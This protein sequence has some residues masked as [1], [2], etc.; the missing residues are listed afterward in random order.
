M[1]VGI[2]W[3]SGNRADI[4]G[5]GGRESAVAVRPGLRRLVR[6]RAPRSFLPD[7]RGDQLGHEIEEGGELD[8]QGRRDGTR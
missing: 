8:G 5:F 1:G 2:C 3:E 4:P 7:G 6:R